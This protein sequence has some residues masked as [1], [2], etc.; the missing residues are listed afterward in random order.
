MNILEHGIQE[1]KAGSPFIVME[2]ISN[3]LHRYSTCVSSSFIIGYLPAIQH[4]GCYVYHVTMQTLRYLTFNVLEINTQKLENLL[5][6]QIN[7]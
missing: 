1:Y 7:T 5:R 6:K 3:N 4:G 2:Y